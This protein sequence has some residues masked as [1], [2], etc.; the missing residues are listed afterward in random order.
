MGKL[1]QLDNLILSYPH[2]PSPSP[3]PLS[4]S[5]PFTLSFPSLTLTPPLL[6]L[7]YS[8]SPSPSPSPSLPLSLSYCSPDIN[9]CR[10]GTHSCDDN[11]ECR[12]TPGSYTCTCNDGFSGDGFTCTAR[13]SAKPLVCGPGYKPWGQRCMGKSNTLISSKSTK[14]WGSC[15]VADINECREGRHRCSRNAYC[16]NTLGSY[17]CTCASGYTGDGFTC[18]LQQ[19]LV[20]CGEWNNPF[21]SHY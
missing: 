2:S 19:Q 11:A 8:H 13:Q 18:T 5:L 14:Y 3:S 1:S 12:N 20:P 7:S 4:L 9:E 16:S 17:T 15:C 21:L 6:S 10:Y